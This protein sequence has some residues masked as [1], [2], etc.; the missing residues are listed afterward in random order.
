MSSREPPA[1]RTRH[2]TVNGIV[3][4]GFYN[5]WPFIIAPELSSTVAR[6]GAQPSGRT[7]SK[8]VIA[9]CRQL[10]LAGG[11]HE[12][13]HDSHQSTSAAY[14]SEAAGQHRLQQWPA[15]HGHAHEP[16]GKA[17]TWGSHSGKTFG[18]RAAEARALRGPRSGPDR[19]FARLRA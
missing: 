16:R 5:L 1:A 8:P 19:M 4:H 12:G 18:T 6:L 3:D 11:T 14:L 2:N 13:Y 17:R 15:L 7:G 9:T 10:A